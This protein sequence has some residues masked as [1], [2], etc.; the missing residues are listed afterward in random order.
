LA[1]R[2]SAAFGGGLE[3]GHT[4]PE[5]LAAKE[6]IYELPQRFSAEFARRAGAL[7]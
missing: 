5:E 7:P 2:L 3:S 6:H 1:F 4:V